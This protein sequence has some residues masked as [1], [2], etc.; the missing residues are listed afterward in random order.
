MAAVT[1]TG[2]GPV[3]VGHDGQGDAI[4][5]ILGS[6][7]ERLEGPDVPDLTSVASLAGGIVAGTSTTSASP[8]WILADAW[9]RVSLE[10][11]S[12]TIKAVAAT[13]TG[14]AIAGDDD[15]VIRV[16]INRE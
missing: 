13:G 9:T 11:A 6:E 14:F 3:A 2:R 7:P 4:V 16:W 15:V 10:L 12:A 1:L 8:V 5:W